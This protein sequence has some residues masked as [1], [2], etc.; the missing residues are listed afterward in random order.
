MDPSPR[1]YTKAEVD[2]F[3]DIWEF[4][5]ATVAD[6]PEPMFVMWREALWAGDDDCVH[7]VAHAPGGGVR[8]TK[9]PGWFCY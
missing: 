1:R 3:S 9:C 4:K 6:D 8:C 2:K 7:D 5:D